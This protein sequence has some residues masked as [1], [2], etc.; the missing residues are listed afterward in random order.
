M[1]APYTTNDQVRAVLGVS[2][3]ELLDATLDLP[4]Y[5]ANLRQE[6]A[7]VGASAAVDYVTATGEG[8]PSAV[9]QAFIDAVTLFAPTAVALHL[10]QS[11]PLFVVKQVTDGKAAATRHTDSPF[12][13]AI[14]ACRKN[15][16]RFRQALQRTYAV[17]K[18]VSAPNVTATPTLFAGSQP[19]SDPVTGT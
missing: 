8:T 7:A 13:G 10:A 12:Q 9:D 1:L 17:Y 11:L 14:D 19:S 4:I 16:E 18:S 2:E 6:L 3:E 5:E 15:Y